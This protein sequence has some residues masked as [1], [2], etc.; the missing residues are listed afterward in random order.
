MRKCRVVAID[1]GSDAGDP[2]S[3]LV[4]VVLKYQSVHVSVC[5]VQF[6]NKYMSVECKNLLFNN[7]YATALLGARMVFCPAALLMNE[8]LVQSANER[9]V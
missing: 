7:A 5:T 8:S 9:S 6:Y 2:G 4:N 1:L 3:Y